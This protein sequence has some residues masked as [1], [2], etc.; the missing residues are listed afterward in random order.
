MK[1]TGIAGGYRQNLSERIG[2]GRLT[3][4]PDGKE[5]RQKISLDPIKGAYNTLLERT[6]GVRKRILIGGSIAS[7]HFLL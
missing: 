1:R 7:R 3:Q 4:D 6:G 2:Y 5:K